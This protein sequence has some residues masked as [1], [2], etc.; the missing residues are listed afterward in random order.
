MA[1]MSMPPNIGMPLLR[2]AEKASLS[3]RATRERDVAE[4]NQRLLISI[5]VVEFAA[6][7]NFWFF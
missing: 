6:R 1:V 3:R 2:L 4:A 5:K 7:K